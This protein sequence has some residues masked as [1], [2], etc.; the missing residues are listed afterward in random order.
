MALEDKQIREMQGSGR[1]SAKLEIEA[2]GSILPKPHCPCPN[3]HPSPI[4]VA[5]GASMGSSQ[6]PPMTKLMMGLVGA[7]SF[8]QSG[9]WLHISS[10]QALLP[11][12]SLSLPVPFLLSVSPLP[13]FPFPSISHPHCIP[14]MSPH[15]SHAMKPQF[16]NKRSQN[17]LPPWTP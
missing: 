17:K 11:S 10:L 15:T 12:P 4:P 3:P 9:S 6:S 16:R 2:G 5:Q 8:F 13:A 1:G 7:G 14:A